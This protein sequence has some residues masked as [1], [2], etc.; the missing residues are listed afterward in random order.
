VLSYET[1]PQVITNPGVASY[2]A[3]TAKVGTGIFQPPVSG[4]GYGSL[5]NLIDFTGDGRPD[6]VFTANGKLSIAAG[7]AGMSIGTPA[8][9]N[10][11]TFTRPLLDTRSSD[12]DRFTDE[13][14]VSQTQDYVWTQ[15]IDVNG[16]GRIDIIDA[17][18]KQ[19]TWVVYLNTPDSGPSG[20]KW[21]RRAYDV[22]NLHQRLIER[23]LGI[24]GNYVPLSLR[25]TGR[26]HGV[27]TCW[28]LQNGHYALIDSS[29]PSCPAPTHAAF[30]GP[31]QTY[32]EYEVT[33]INGDGYPDVVLNSSRVNLVAPPP[34][35]IGNDQTI[36]V[37]ELM[38]LH[39][40]GTPNNVE[41]AYNVR[42]LFI[43][44]D[45]TPTDPF[46]S[47]QE[48]ISASACGVEKWVGDDSDGDRVQV[49]RCALAD[50][51]GDGLIDRIEDDG[52]RLGTGYSF[53][54]TVTLKVPAAASRKFFAVQQSGFVDTCNAPGASW[55]NS[56]QTVGL[57]DL[58]GDGIPDLI[59]PKLGGGWEVFVGT[60][61]RFAATA[62]DI[63][64]TFSFSHA[65]EL[66]DGSTSNT[67]SGVYDVDGDGKPD[68]VQVNGGSIDVYRL[69]GGS[70]PG[71]PE[72]GK[73]VQ[74][75]NGYGAV[76]SITYTS[77]KNDATTQHQ[78]PFPEIVVA[79]IQTT[80][81]LNLGG[82]LAA[83][84][85]AYGNIDLY[86]DSTADAFRTTG[87]KRRVELVSIPGV[88]DGSVQSNATI[89]D[90]YPLDP[91]NPVTWPFL[92]EKQRFG[93]YLQ[94]GLISDVTTL[95]GG[96]SSDAWSLLT[97]D[98]TTDLRR[99]GGVHHSVD[100]TDTHWFADITPPTDDVCKEVMYPYDY[101]L[102]VAN[103]YGNY[104]PCSAR[105]FLYTRSTQ[106][107]RGTAAP[108]SDQNVQIY[109][110]IRSVDDYGRITSM[111][112]QNDATQN[113]D[114]VCVDTTYATP[115]DPT[116]H[117]L[118]AI[119]SRKVWACGDKGD[120]TTRAEESFEYDK[121]VTGLVFQGLPTSHTVYRHATDTGAWLSTVRE[122]DADYDVNGD[123][124]QVVTSRL[125]ASRTTQISYDPFGLAPT[126]TSVTG[127]S[128]LPLSASQEI[129]PITNQV[130]SQTDENGTIRGTTFDGFGRPVLQTIR[131]RGDVA[132]GVLAAHTYLGFQGGDPLGRR[133][134]V[135]E[136]TDPVTPKLVGTGVG[137]VATSYFDEV[138][139]SRFAQVPLGDDY[140]DDT[141][142]V[143]S[144]TYDPLGRVTF[145]AD[146]YPASQ[147]PTSAYGTTRYFD[148]DGSLWLEIRGNG[149]QPFTTAPDATKELFPSQYRHTFANHLETTTTQ[150]ADSLTTGSLQFGVIRQASSTA[151]GR[152]L[153]RSTTQSGARIEFETF[154][155]ELLGHQ[156]ALTRYQDPAGGSNPVTSSWKFDSLGQILELD[157]PTSAPQTRTYSDWGELTAVT[158]SPVSPEP[159]HSIINGYDA[160]GR[161]T[162]SEEQ[163][164][165]TTDPATYN[166]YSY[167]VPGTSPYVTPANVGGRLASASGPTGN[168]V[169]SYDGFGNVNARSYTDV[170]SNIYVEQQGFHGDG[171]QASITLQLPDNS[172]QPERLDY[173]YDTAGRMR[174]MWFSDGVNTQELYSAK[175]LDVWGRDRDGLLGN[176]EYAA[177]YADLGRR[178][179]KN[180]KVTSTAGTRA[181]SFTGF[182]ALAREASRT[183]DIPS[184][185]NHSTTSYDALGRLQTTIRTNGTTTTAKWDFAYDALGNVTSLHDAV[186]SS[187]A[188]LTY[189]TT[190][191]DRIC[192]V[193]FTV[194][195]TNCNVIHDS[196]GNITTEPTRA[197]YNK[198]AYFNS[199]DVRT[200]V[201]QA[202]A[203][204]TFAYDPFG[205]L[206]E[207]TID[208]PT[209]SRHDR[210]FG[211]FITQRT[212]K[213]ASASAS[214]MARRF[215]GPG[216]SL[217]RRGP[218]GSWVYE[219]SEPS[220]T[221]FTTDE[222]GNFLQDLR[223]TPFGDTTSTGVPPGTDTFTTDQWNDGDAL[224][225]FGLVKVGKRIYD[226]ALGR[227]L[228]RDPL[229]TPRTS[230][231]TNPYAFS[232]NDPSNRSDPSG[233]D[234]I[235]N[236]GSIGTSITTGGDANA[237][238]LGATEALGVWAAGYFFA[239]RV[240]P[241]VTGLSPSEVTSFSAY[242]DARMSALS[243]ARANADNFAQFEAEVEAGR[244]C[245][246]LEC[247][248]E[249]FVNGDAAVGRFLGAVKDRL[250]SLPARIVRQSERA[251]AG[252]PPTQED[253]DTAV[254]MLF[255]VAGSGRGGGVRE[256]VE[257]S[258]L[259]G[260]PRPTGGDL[261]Y[262]GGGPLG[263]VSGPSL[264]VEQGLRLGEKWVGKG[265]REMGKIRGS[266]VFRSADG[267]RQFR[268]TEWD[269]EGT[270]GKI[271]PHIHFESFDAGGESLENLHIPLSD[272]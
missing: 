101:D 257:E 45:A 201:N 238:L 38:Q 55:F 89:I 258:F 146:A 6:F 63:E 169:F 223:Y 190:D 249:R 153:S 215:P 103:N 104:N 80:G 219:F 136:F 131:A 42:G 90:R 34:P 76:T 224:D 51:N 144:R 9:L 82:T 252:S 97:V 199:G 52:A 19:N 11:A 140:A 79:S 5:Q 167:D 35:D 177:T 222:K 119:A 195:P 234:P 67:A 207:L 61:A 83:T 111:F 240:K 166:K 208:G 39:P 105:G 3:D 48:L 180:V 106:S 20:I 108:P 263:N 188:F 178:L 46:S 161:V 4:T 265:Y 54:Y 170:D 116:T 123:P 88:R 122:Y 148:P 246:G 126:S 102:S 179:P 47:P 27:W 1:S 211:A 260:L 114:D 181:I 205:E 31:E 236:G 94:A 17:A 72:S 164:D 250:L 155:Y 60:G 16:D 213:T 255:I 269:I 247:I 159:K 129:D 229:L 130:L 251:E 98:V 12:V 138:G 217:S 95:A 21:V 24:S 99:I 37:E 56:T 216:L 241:T 239:T 30:V 243:V 228:S 62:T 2:V 266:G 71:N 233:M 92:S 113:D 242:F 168:V 154:G 81:T 43:S 185:P 59:E 93:R 137:R 264:T 174:W 193:S 112:Y 33:D 115:T 44:S 267:L 232:M 53:N 206:Q 141:L 133:L 149:P 272:K 152:V 28:Q 96:F 84:R 77:A 124:I 203:T 175:Q 196:F 248:H 139:R 8:P 73:I 143:G 197:G 231:T 268:I 132:P 107:W 29:D 49:A 65:D 192:S 109:T 158:W 147:D 78:V 86:Y 85:Y 176:T 198:L 145:E 218:K 271:G 270:H 36:L 182:D 13:S 262:S 121:L 22:T 142:I 74:V 87:Y 173:A 58:T 162:Y 204:A 70:Q 200:I 244:P 214:Y 237:P 165:G 120:G 259:D 135:E 57:R 202:K 227:F 41:V 220:G 75:D 156:T 194:S 254:D 221:R 230:A 32:V 18:E 245:S 150:E 226:P 160:L 128:L 186:T 100:A 256:A 10:D 235:W 7:L 187:N 26:D 212:Q 68:V 172:Y 151:I 25:V 134:S 15:S 184:A 253:S 125:G 66:C 157:E 209:G 210:N 64:G 69:T 14:S 23:G 261:H 183:E 118:S 163:N 50:V 91:V 225:G 127:T 189:L 40:T 171:S 117:V 191:R 110:S